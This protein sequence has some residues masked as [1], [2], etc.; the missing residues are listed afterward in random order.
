MDAQQKEEL[1]QLLC[2][3][4]KAFSLEPNETG[5]C[6]IL[7]CDIDTGKARPI[8]ARARRVQ[9]HLRRVIETQV[10]EYL[11]EGVITES[12]SPWAAPIVMVRKKTGEWRMCIDFR[13]LNKVTCKDP[14][15]IPRC[16]DLLQGS[17]RGRYF[18]TLDQR[19]GYHQLLVTRRAREKLAFVV[20]QVR[21]RS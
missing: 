11:E 16:E 5:I 19:K 18:T 4:D 15:P 10:K 2:E 3:H 13:D 14:Y 21:T 8:S 12:N 6:D 7:K 1:I 20:I 17:H 9:P